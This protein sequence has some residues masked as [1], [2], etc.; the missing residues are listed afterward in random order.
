MT[1]DSV[2]YSRLKKFAYESIANFFILRIYLDFIAIL[3]L[4]TASGVDEVCVALFGCCGL[5]LGGGGWF[6]FVW[7]DLLRLV[8]LSLGGIVGLE[9]HLGWSDL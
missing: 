6:A 3:I 1:M 7:I 8:L 2:V 5:F 4:E 9:G